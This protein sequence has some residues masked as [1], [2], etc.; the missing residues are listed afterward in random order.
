MT[1][2]IIVVNDPEDFGEYT[3]NGIVV[4]AFRGDE[5]RPR[6]PNLPQ[7]QRLASQL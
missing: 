2:T 1:R 3:A 6:L 4:P 7:I 5:R